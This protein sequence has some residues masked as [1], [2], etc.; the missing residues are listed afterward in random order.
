MNRSYIFWSTLLRW[1]NDHGRVFPWRMSN[2]AYHVFIAEFLLQQ[3]HVRK[4]EAVYWD[5]L[6]RYPTPELLSLATTGEL[7][8]VIS[9]L[10]LHYRAR[11]LRDACQFIQRSHNGIIPSNYTVLTRMTGI[12]DYIANAVLCY[13][14]GQN[15]VP[16]DTN[17]IRLFTRYFGLSSVCARARTDRKLATSI[18]ELFPR[19]ANHRNYNLAILDFAGLVCTAK[20]PSCGNC[21]LAFQCSYKKKTISTIQLS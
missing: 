5:I 12:G 8:N 11:R 15:T 1:F 18:R 20:Q 16:I 2:N 3:T 4:V 19:H 17:V 14:F 13:G 7:I 10:G 21:P 6:E 9:P